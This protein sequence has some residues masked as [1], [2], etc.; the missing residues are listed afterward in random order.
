MASLLPVSLPL[1]NTLPPVLPPS[2]PSI[3]HQAN[4][5]KILMLSDFSP[6]LKTRDIMALFGDWEDDK[7]GFKIKWCDDS[8]CWIVFSDA[9]VAKRAFLTLLANRPPA[10]QPTPGNNPKLTAY[11]GADATQILTAV[12]NR[13]RSRS[14]ANGGHS[15]KG[16]LAG[17][18][19]GAALANQMG[20]ANGGHARA[21][22]FGRASRGSYGQKQLWEV[23]DQ[24]GNP[25]EGVTTGEERDGA[26]SPVGEVAKRQVGGSMGHGRSDSLSI[27]D[28]PPTID[29]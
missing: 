7:G 5:T 9:A 18:G 27:A 15:R 19:G 16:S 26:V 6:E 25:V 8:S 21:P 29:E 1:T 17:S 24:Q 12:Q 22:S 3:Q 20:G 23:M 14:V 2:F 13:P 28:L 4:Q 11:T 10:L